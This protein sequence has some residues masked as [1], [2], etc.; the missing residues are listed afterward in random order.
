MNGPGRP[1][2]A[3]VE[4]RRRT[5]MVFLVG[6]AAASQDVVTRLAERAETTERTI[7]ADLDALKEQLD[8]CVRD[9]L[10]Q[11]LMRAIDSTTSYKDLQ[12]LV[13]RVMAA[14]ANE[15]ITKDVASTLLEGISVQRH[16][17][18]AEHEEE[19]IEA[20]RALELLTPEEEALLADYRRKLAGP[21]V[22]P[23]EAVPP[24]G[25]SAS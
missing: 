10:P 3:S 4:E 23:G 5:I 11:E 9:E 20:I 8:S 7:R 25:G 21:P 1:T 24:P 13:S 6:S 2:K 16:L 18:R 19:P 17:I 12:S 22:Q 14:S 15:K